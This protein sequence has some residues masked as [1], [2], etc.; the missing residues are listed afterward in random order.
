MA[1]RPTMSESTNLTEKDR[2]KA[3]FL[4]AAER[5]ADAIAGLLADSPTEELLGKTEF[6]LRDAVLK[7][8][9]K[10]LEGAANERAKKRGTKGA[11]PPAT[12]EHPLAL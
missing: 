3:L 6:A 10:T 5:E 2:I 1:R 7:L 12:A 11:A 9:A 4:E 8:G